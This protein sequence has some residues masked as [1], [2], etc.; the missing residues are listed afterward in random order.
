MS[1]AKHDGGRP[2]GLYVQP[3]LVR[4]YFAAHA[5]ASLILKVPLHDRLG[6]H[7]V[8]TPEV[9]DIHQ[10]RRDIAA[11]A[12]DYAAA[13]LDARKVASAIAEEDDRIAA[14]G[15]DLLREL[16]SLVERVQLAD[17]G[18]YDTSDAVAAITKAGGSVECP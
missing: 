15:P 17:P 9:D 13:M 6:E 12:Y 10:V 2:T 3:H 5:M 8:H 11:S 1:D 7:G 16:V 18:V 4:D 14:A